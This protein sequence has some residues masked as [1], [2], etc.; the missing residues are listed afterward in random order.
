MKKRLAIALAV[1]VLSVAPTNGYAG[2]TLL[3]TAEDLTTSTASSGGMLAVNPSDTIEFTVGLASL[4]PGQQLNYLAVDFVPTN[5]DNPP[6]SPTTI[7]NA[8]AIVPDLTGFS[9]GPGSV[10]AFYDAFLSS[11]GQNITTT[12]IFYTFQ[13]MVTASSPFPYT[14][15]LSS[16]GSAYDDGGGITSFADLPSLALTIQ[17]VPEP[18]SLILAGTGCALAGL[19]V[20]WKRR[21][22]RID[23]V[24][25]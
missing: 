16:G 20:G 7:P 1:A 21:R 9:S 23:A 18:S 12:G 17:A 24:N 8:G 25:S 19:R 4:A 11:S 15:M 5:L 6:L 3:L 10:G 13:A 14:V 2:I 22:S